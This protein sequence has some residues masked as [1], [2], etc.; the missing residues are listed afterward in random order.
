MQL[1]IARNFAEI[2]NEKRQEALSR[3]PGHWRA[4]N[5]VLSVIASS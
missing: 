5:A 1:Q 4:G 3:S 2:R